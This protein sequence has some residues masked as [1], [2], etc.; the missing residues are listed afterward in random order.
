MMSDWLNFSLGRIQWASEPIDSHIDR[1]LRPDSAG[2]HRQLF[3]W[4]NHVIFFF[5]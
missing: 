1:P 3:D 2:L 5:I 4:L